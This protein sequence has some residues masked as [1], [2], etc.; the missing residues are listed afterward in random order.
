L[1]S[2]PYCAPAKDTRKNAKAKD[3][4][5]KAHIAPLKKKWM[6]QRLDMKITL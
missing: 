2:H 4:I 5:T 1:D 3:K 6:K